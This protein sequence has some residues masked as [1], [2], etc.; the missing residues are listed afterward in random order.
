MSSMLRYPPSTRF[1]IGQEVKT[2]SRSTMT[3]SIEG[4]HSRMY[5]A[6]VAPPSPPPITT[7]RP[8]DAAVPAQPASDNAPASFR[9]SLRFM[10]ASFLLR[11]EVPGKQVD[12]RVGIALGDLV[13]YGGGPLAL[14]EGLHLRHQELL[15]LPG[16]RGDLPGRAAPIGAVAVGAGGSQ[17]ARDGAVLGVG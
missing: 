12:L 6:A 3:T 15:R 9:K 17:A 13:H 16:E 4:S 2:F 5:L 8:F 11:R 7:T 10:I 1:E 14:L